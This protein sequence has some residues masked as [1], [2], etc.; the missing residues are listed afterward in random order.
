VVISPPPFEEIHYSIVR[1]DLE[2]FLELVVKGTETTKKIFGW[3]LLHFTVFM[4]NLQMSRIL[5]DHGV[6]IYDYCD[7]GYT[8]LHLAVIYKHPDIVELILKVD[9]A[10]RQVM[11]LQDLCI[12]NLHD[13]A[14][15]FDKL[16]EDLPVYLKNN[17]VNRILGG[18]MNEALFGTHYPLLLACLSYDERVIHILIDHG[19]VVNITLPD[20]QETPLHLVKSSDLARLLIKKNCNI[21][22]QDIQHNTPLHIACSNGNLD[23]V[24]TLLQSDADPEIQ[25]ENHETPIFCAI[26]SVSNDVCGYLLDKNINIL[27]RDRC[28]R[29]LLHIS[30]EHLHL[31]LIY[32]LVS[33][34]KIPLSSTDDKGRTVLDYIDALPHQ[35]YQ[36]RKAQL[37]S[38]FSSLNKQ[39]SP[40]NDIQRLDTFTKILNEQE[41]NKRM[42]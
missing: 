27:Q 31:D 7:L 33:F 8:P 37:Y 41:S 9:E 1:N 21:N 10:N 6:S 22:A 36:N 35:H 5:I 13:Q 4:G 40:S 28:G 39:T 30:V 34:R 14:Y 29:T 24:K 23:L 38:I 20:T 17:L 18:E 19:A 42:Y 2:L 15:P 16:P 25:N 26:K 12:I 3:S 11:T 32:K